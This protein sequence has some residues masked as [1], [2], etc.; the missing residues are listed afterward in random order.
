MSEKITIDAQGNKVELMTF[1]D[2]MKNAT[3]IAEKVAR[4]WSKQTMTSNKEM[5][6][7]TARVYSNLKR[8]HPFFA[9]TYPILLLTMARGIIDMDSLR[10]HFKDVE[11]MGSIG[12]DDDQINRVAR[13]MAYASAN[14][15]KRKN[16]K[17]KIRESDVKK[18]K[19]EYANILKGDK[20][21]MKDAVEAIKN[22]REK[23]RDAAH[24]S[25]TADDD[26]SAKKLDDLRD[27]LLS[28]L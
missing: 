22:D 7:L 28:L 17:V 15:E 4:F 2:A 12:N 9:A 16:P 20:K 3:E 25:T 11:M 19:K 24:S 18:K 14:M 23:S 6:K 8:D 21:N 13:Y 1:N 10:V 5:D 27:E 26:E